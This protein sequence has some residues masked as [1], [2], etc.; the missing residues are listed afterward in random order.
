V[1]YLSVTP[2]TSVNDSWIIG[3]QID[4]T[5]IRQ[6]IQH[7][8]VTDNSGTTI[9][10]A[11]FYKKIALDIVTETVFNYPYPYVSE[12]TLRPINCK[13]MF[14]ILGPKGQLAYLKSLGINT[15]GDLID[16]SYDEIA[17]PETRF[18]HVVQE[19]KKFCALDLEQIKQYYVNN[20]TKFDHNFQVLKNLP[21]R[22]IQNFL[23]K[24]NL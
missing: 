14:I 13:R 5:P 17:D 20:K 2:Y 11:D 23:E 21:Q 22:E 9:Y 6:N 12:K 1:N 18:L 3:N 8:V 10:G 15:F 24:Y 4:A 16:E 7:P 19:I